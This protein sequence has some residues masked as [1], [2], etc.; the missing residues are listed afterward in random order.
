MNEKFA[1]RIALPLAKIK[2]AVAAVEMELARPD[3]DPM[4]Y[5]R[6]GYLVGELSR[7]SDTLSMESINTT[8]ELFN[9]NPKK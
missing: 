6:I 1:E 4:S 5:F 8:M 9:P 2:A 3:D 7:A